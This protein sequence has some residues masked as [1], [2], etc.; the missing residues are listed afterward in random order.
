[1]REVIIDSAQPVSRLWL[2]GR[3]GRDL[4]NDNQSM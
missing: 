4:S 2:M 1:M 3:L